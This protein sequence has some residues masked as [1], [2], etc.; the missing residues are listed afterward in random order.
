MSSHPVFKYLINYPPNGVQY[1]TTKKYTLKNNSHVLRVFK[2]HIWKALTSFRPPYVSVDSG[3]SDLIHSCHGMLIS[4]KS[5][6]I[7]D[8]EHAP[9]FANYKAA[10]LLKPQYRDQIIR[11]LSSENCKKILPWTEASKRSVENA[12]KNNKINKKLQVIYPAIDVKNVRIKRDTNVIKFL[13]VSRFFYEKG[14]KQ[15]LEVFEKLDK[16]YDV[17]ICILSPTPPEIKR[18]YEKF[19]NVKFVEKIFV[20][21]QKPNSIFEDYYSKYDIL[22]HFTFADTFGLALL[23]AMSCSMPII[24]TDMFSMP[25]LIEDE[26][27][28]FLVKSSIS[29]LNPDFSIK[30]HHDFRNMDIFMNRIKGKNEQLIQDAVSKASLLIENTNLRRKMGCYGKRLV[31]CGKFSIKERNKKLKF[32]YDESI[33]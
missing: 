6:W 16:K 2:K 28:G 11:F 9:S 24:G 32:V 31:E 27:N 12:L 21:S 10:S 7:V 19:K 15:A 33:R 20:T 1:T 22:F 26:K 5:P 23:E 4:N 17:E 13:V 25:E 3:N 30:Y 18:K 8:V 29:S 14:G